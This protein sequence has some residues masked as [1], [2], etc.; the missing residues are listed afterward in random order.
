MGIW[1]AGVDLSTP[2]LYMQL[3]T[4][5]ESFC[6]SYWGLLAWRTKLLNIF[7]S[8]TRNNLHAPSSKR[9]CFGRRHPRLFQSKMGRTNENQDSQK[10]T[11]LRNSWVCTSL[12]NPPPQR[13]EPLAPETLTACNSAQTEVIT[14]ESWFT[15]QRFVPRQIRRKRNTLFRS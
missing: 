5:A 3:I 13:K 1:R 10:V 14:R 11:K 8:T 4:G 12:L 9:T 2:H 6:C 7:F 15:C